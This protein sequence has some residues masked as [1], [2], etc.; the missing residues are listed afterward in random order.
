MNFAGARAR[1]RRL[2]KSL[3]KSGFAELFCL[4]FV[5]GEN[6]PILPLVAI[7]LLASLMLS[8]YRL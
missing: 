2:G 4:F 8:H 6:F 7:R 5:A 3:M 1:R